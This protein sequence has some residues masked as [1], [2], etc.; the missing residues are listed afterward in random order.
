MGRGPRVGH[1]AVA[2]VCVCVWGGVGV[3]GGARYCGGVSKVVGWGWLGGSDVVVTWVVAVVA[4]F[5]NE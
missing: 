5:V 1:V 4:L 3:C 2:C